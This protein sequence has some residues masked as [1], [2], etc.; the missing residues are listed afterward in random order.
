MPEGRSTAWGLRTGP[1]MFTVRHR[2]PLRALSSPLAH[3]H[4]TLDPRPSRVCALVCTSGVTGGCLA[5]ARSVRAAQA[6][7]SCTA[8]WALTHGTVSICTEANALRW[9][10]TGPA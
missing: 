7:Q 5:V 4:K 10:T 2:F 8:L 9:C 6:P 3:L 1:A